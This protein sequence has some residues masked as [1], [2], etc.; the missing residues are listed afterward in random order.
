[1]SSAHHTVIGEDSGS[2]LGQKRRDA[3]A[4][5]DTAKFSRF[6]VKLCFVAG[7][8]FFTDAYDLFSISIVA[9]MLGYVYSPQNASTLGINQDFG[10]KVAAPMGNLVGQLL[11]G[12][13]AD[14]LG[15]KKMY[16]VELM[17]MIVATFGQTISTDSRG[18]G[19]SITGVIV[20]WRFI[21]GIGVGGDYPL[22]SVIASE[23]AST[24]IRGR[25]MTAVFAFQGWGNLASA[26]V[27][28]ITILA[29]RTHIVNDSE[30]FRAID[31]AWRLII[32]LGIVPACIALYFRLTIPE[33]PRFT[34]DIERNIIQA[35]EDVDNVLSHRDFYVDEQALPAHADVPKASRR[36][37]VRYF[38]QRDNLK[39]LF[40]TA[41]SWFS[42]DIA[43]YG[44]G[45]NS[46]SIIQTVIF[47]GSPQAQTGQERYSTLRTVAIGNI[48]LA[49]GGLIPGYWFSFF[50]IDTW[51][52][53]PIQFI[54]FAMLTILFL[55]M[56]VGYDAINRTKP[57]Q[58]AFVFLYCLANFFQN[59]GPN[60]TTFI[61]PGEA[62]PTRYRST[63]HG[64]SAASGKLGAVV[65]Q[66][67]FAYLRNVSVFSDNSTNLRIVFGIFA[68]FMFTGIGSTLLIPETKGKTLEELSNE[69]QDGFFRYV[70]REFLMS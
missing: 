1:M 46:S 28:V 66:I 55:I 70:L 22:S 2:D 34:M 31:R 14:V 42:I 24:R 38:R 57:G 56:C 12:W 33:T 10:I 63:A 44:L 49:F 25:L 20:V 48:I 7:I 51:G 8:G 68:V 17:I 5:L 29:F 61:V 50:T 37:F 47:P 9:T 67:L 23:F 45:F 19:V 18:L 15:R 54:G 32:G 13:L 4:E 64:I 11:F 59:W 69:D 27:S 39:T 43:F 6:H 30:S 16:G 41:W 58:R 3:L 26:I 62:F 40:G 36:D 52:R 60:T 65:T 53:K 21:L 35:S